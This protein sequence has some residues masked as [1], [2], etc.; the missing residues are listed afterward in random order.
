MIKSPIHKHLLY[1]SAIILLGT[2][3]MSSPVRA[4]EDCDKNGVCT[5]PEFVGK[6]SMDS[7]VSL[8]GIGL[9]APNSA[10]YRHLADEK[11]TI[12]S[13]PKLGK[14]DKNESV[15]G[16]ESGVYQLNM[17]EKIQL[18]ALI[19]KIKNQN[20]RAIKIKGF[21]DTQSLS[22]EA[23]KYY[24]DNQDLSLKR[25]Q[26]AEKYIKQSMDNQ[27]LPITVSGKGVSNQNSCDEYTYNSPEYKNCLAPNRRIDIMVW[28]EK[29]MEACKIGQPLNTEMPFRIS[30]DGAPVDD[31]D[32]ANSADVTRCKDIALEKSDIQLRF[33]PLEKTQ[34]LN[35]TAFPRAVVR[36][37]NV[38]FTPYT[39]YKFYIDR[40]EV[41]I[42]EEGQSVQSKP[43]SVVPVDASLESG[44]GWA[45]PQSSDE[46][47][48]QYVL[49]VYDKKGRFDET[50]PE[51]IKLVD[52][53]R[54]DDD[55]ESQSRETLIGYGENNL[56]IQNIPV[57]GGIVTVNG[58]KLAPG[59]KVHV[60]GADVPVDANGRFVYRQ[61]LP[62]GEHAISIKTEDSK[63]TKSEITRSA[64]LP[65]QDWFYVGIA[66]ITAGKNSV[67][68]PASI[69]TG[70]D[71]KRYNGDFYIDGRLAFYAKGKLKK[72]WELT[73]SADTKEQPFEDLFSNFT[74]KDPRYLLKRID[75]NKYYQVY[76]D[77][78]T[79]VEDAQ[80]QG[81]F[82]LKVEK[83]DSHLMWGNF[84]TKITGTDLL[85][86][87]RTLYGANAEYTSAGMTEFGERRTELDLFAADPGSIASME[88]FRGTGGSLYYLGGQDVVVGSER[89][90]IETRDRDSGI[91][92]NSQYLTYGQ[93][94][95]INYLQ[96]RV[97]L[98]E[99]LSSS[100]TEGSIVRT[101]S[102]SGNPVYL[103][104][105]Y[106]YTPGVSDIDNLTKGGR[107]S[108]WL[109]DNIRLGASIYDQNGTGLDQTLG[110]FDAIMRYTPETYLKLEQ[111]RSLGAGNGS[112]SSVNG[113]FNFDSIDQT[114]GDID[115]DAYRAEI[116][117]SIGDLIKG[118]EGTISA[119]TLHR[120]DGYSAPGQLTDEEVMQYGFNA[121][122]PVSDRLTV[123][124][125]FDFRQGNETGDLTNA[126]INGGLD[127][128]DE[129]NLTLAIRHDDRSSSAYGE[130]S[131]IL[132]DEGSRTDVAAKYLYAPL[133][134]QGEKER[135]EVYGLAQAT[136]DKSGDRNRNNRLGV[137]GRY[138][139]SDR[140]NLNG[141]VSGGNQ[142]LG[143]LI[144]L[145]YL[146]S[147]RTSYYANYEIDNQRTDI[148]SRGKNTALTLGG[149]SRYSD[150]LS[151]F[152]EERYQT[153][154]NDAS[155]LIHSYGL[156]LSA[157]DN[158]TWGGRFENGVITD[159]EAGDTDRTAV[160]LTTGYAAQDTK[161]SGVIEYRRDDNDI[162]GER[163]SWLMNNNLAYQTN[164]DWRLLAD[165]GI[166]FS[167][168]GLS[169]DLDA[170]FMELGLGYAYRPI[171]ND[172]LNALV[173]YEYLS[174]LAP[175]DQ[176]NATRTGSASD[177]EQRSHV[178]SADAIYDVTPK[179]AVGAK[180]GYRISEIRDTT[181]DGSDFFDSQAFLLVGRADYHVVKDWELTGELRYLEASEAE[182]SKTG[183]LIGVYKHL[184][185]N[186]KVG[187][188][189]N[190]TDFSDDLTDLDYDSEGVFINAI[191]K[192]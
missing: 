95:E 20:I 148:G 162:D 136:V 135:Y 119:Y 17:A 18:N 57:S 134:E 62:E 97:I 28:Y 78:S 66:D 158:W 121:S 186:F 49:R 11:V 143:A 65:E 144:G 163:D 178:V 37:E 29:P 137:G 82:Y 56:S 8:R 153:F 118:Q 77:D 12:Y 104:A 98:R 52:K 42:F 166:A 100:S 2:S 175:D 102:L 25:A 35:V 146:K 64:Y 152:A 46:R 59:S 174:D 15:A 87:N 10:E 131:A 1:T 58:D 26:E 21:A 171:D 176:Q 106:E 88:E 128:T 150:S 127:L 9:D 36:G 130:N 192:F 185:Q 107:L 141:E 151:V 108:H 70:D 140:L 116:G 120:E 109:N 184:N 138:D 189:Y 170:D 22:D 85:N 132:S 48:L 190:F 112:L 13:R 103:V 167:N 90:R 14:S 80:T 43:L 147:D 133:N 159:K 183:A 86:Y 180:V 38:V 61:I 165:F 6:Q 44:I 5:E 7:R 115:A 160:S 169:S 179:L 117:L 76:G 125:K 41:R 93:D 34:A 50:K 16:F 63:G 83:D 19:S 94:Y 31:A 156:D 105:G 157:G 142:G 27:S 75:P 89:L 139:V 74:E 110:G 53:Q 81:K 4:D 173:R 69:V 145:E 73:A 54:P 30:V 124:S 72:G 191:G 113:G 84:Q 172:R 55:F 101:G 40:A 122:V 177:F 23:K 68:G 92:L 168:A 126:E 154:D 123:G 187:A 96:G 188:G 155:S 111:A 47:L 71:S 3:F 67:D 182:D 164:E 181:V 91:V 45:S 79:A 60:L 129:T 99:S 33:D 24:A 114:A 51:V 149:K 32:R 161:Y 39:N